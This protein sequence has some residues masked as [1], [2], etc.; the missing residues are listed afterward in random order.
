MEYKVKYIDIEGKRHEKVYK[1]NS[2]KEVIENFKKRNFEIINITLLNKKSKDI[3]IFSSN[4]LKENIVTEFLKQFSLLL[5]SG[6]DIKTA[7]SFLYEQET[8]KNLR[9]CLQSIVY[10]LDSG[11]TLGESFELSEKFPNL[12]PGV[13]EAGEFSSEL[14]ASMDM[15]ASYYENES[16]LKQ[17]IRNAMYYP[18]ILLIVTGIIVV[19][20]VTFVLPNYVALFQSYE[21]LELPWVTSLLINSSKFFSKYFLFLPM[22]VIILFLLIRSLKRNKNINFTFSQILL[23]TPILGKFIINMEI[24]RFSGVFS[25]LIKSGVETIKA[26]EIASKSLSNSYLR[27]SI[28]LSKNSIIKGNTLSSS[29][30]KIEEI[31]KIF[32]NLIN[33]GETSS[34][35]GETMEISYNYYK[36]LVS[37]QSKKITSLFEPLIIILVSLIV[38]TIVIAIALPTFEIVN[39]L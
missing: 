4:T 9:I 13:V 34:K 30:N 26:I 10:Y 3:S 35:L 11:H 21:N 12:I 20:I 33:V 16:K 32:L 5:R 22:S 28:L 15:L 36:D 6:M 25:L 8:D 1:F 24:Q 27:E 23:K 31:P 17:N 7:M 2:E 39:I 37:N 14:S 19:G 38:G 18:L 29:L